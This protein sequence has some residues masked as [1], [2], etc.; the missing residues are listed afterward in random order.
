MFIDLARCDQNTYFVHFIVVLWE[1]TDQGNAGQLGLEQRVSAI[2]SDRSAKNT[3]QLCFHNLW[4]LTFMV[5]LF[6]LDT[7][8][9]KVIISNIIGHCF[10]LDISVNIV[11]FHLGWIGS[12]AATLGCRCIPDTANQWALIVAT[13]VYY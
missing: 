1:I 4:H 3:V 13:G 11:M 8:F 5:T 10:A 6:S 9:R 7:P 12:V 2:S